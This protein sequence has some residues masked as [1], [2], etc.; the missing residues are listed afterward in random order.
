MSALRDDQGRPVDAC[1]RPILKR[2]RYT[3]DA[4][5]DGPKGVAPSSSSPRRAEPPDPA[6]RGL[7]DQP[8]TPTES[9][10]DAD[11]QDDPPRA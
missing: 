3:L 1:G 5:Q 7:F 11:D 2:C 8:A 4:F 10:S 9:P 6:Q